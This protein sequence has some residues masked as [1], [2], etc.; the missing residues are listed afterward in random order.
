MRTQVTFDAYI[1]K[2]IGPN[3]RLAVKELVISRLESPKMDI[4]GVPGVNRAARATINFF[5]ARLKKRVANSIQPALRTQLE[6]ALNRL[7]LFG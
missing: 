5:M 1:T 7:P 4:G 3:T 6:Q 2:G